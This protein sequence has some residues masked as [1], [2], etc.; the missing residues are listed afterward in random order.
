MVYALSYLHDHHISDDWMKRQLEEAIDRMST[1]VRDFG[2][3]N[4]Q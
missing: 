4:I 3:K 1:T 2:G